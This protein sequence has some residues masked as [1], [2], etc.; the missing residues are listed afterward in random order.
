M[1]FFE[2]MLYNNNMKAILNK[3]PK[4]GVTF[5][6]EEAGLKSDKSS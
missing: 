4:E 2:D 1:I 3:N 6:F 5:S